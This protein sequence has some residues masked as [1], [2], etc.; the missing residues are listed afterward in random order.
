MSRKFTS[1]DKTLEGSYLK[2]QVMVMGRESTYSGENPSPTSITTCKKHCGCILKILMNSA[3]FAEKW[4]CWFFSMF[5]HF[6]LGRAEVACGEMGMKQ[7]G[8]KISHKKNS[9]VILGARFELP[10]YPGHFTHAREERWASQVVLV[11]KNPPAKA[12]NI[13]D[14]DSILGWEDPWEEAMATHSSIHAW[15]IPWAEEHSGLWSMGA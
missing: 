9:I 15:R 10:E 7:S 8:L 11:V 4:Q 3:K 1:N 14:E 5:S 6:R 2:P 12:G 13:R